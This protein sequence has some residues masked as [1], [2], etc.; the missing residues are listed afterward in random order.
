MHITL[1]DVIKD[2]VPSVEGIVDARV[3]KN[4]KDRGNEQ[5]AGE[6]HADH[7]LEEQQ[8]NVAQANLPA[9]G[10]H[11]DEPVDQRK[12]NLSDEEII[13]DEAAG[14]DCRR[15]NAAAPLVHILIECP[16]QQREEDHRFVEMVE[17]DVV[18]RI[19]GEGIEDRADLRRALRSRIAADKK[20][21]GQ[22][23]EGE[24]EHKQRPHQISHQIAR[25]QQRDPEERTAERIE[26]IG[27]DKVRAEVGYVAPFIIT[28]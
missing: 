9:A 22:R 2:R 24:F 25:E 16:E 1:V 19:S 12:G 7:S 14:K 27:A 28:A 23:S 11:P 17:E 18:D 13:I 21:G 15:K 20:I 5:R 4:R 6:Q 10:N 3:L 26:G 8:Q